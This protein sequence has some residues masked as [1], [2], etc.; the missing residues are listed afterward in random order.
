M[1]NIIKSILEYLHFHF[2][3][4]CDECEHYYDDGDLYN[5][6]ICRKNENPSKCEIR[7]GFKK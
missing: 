4:G 6:P 3:S 2:T 5:F 7:I 1:K